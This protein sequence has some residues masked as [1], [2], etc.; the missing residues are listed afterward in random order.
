VENDTVGL[1]LKT[2]DRISPSSSRLSG[3]DS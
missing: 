2:L 1:L 3:Y